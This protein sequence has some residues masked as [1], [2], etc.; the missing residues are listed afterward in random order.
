[1][2]YRITIDVLDVAR[3]DIQSLVSDIIAEHGNSF[4]IARGDFEISVS[5]YRDGNLFAIDIHEEA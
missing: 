4:D 1:M 5:E 2:N 3:G